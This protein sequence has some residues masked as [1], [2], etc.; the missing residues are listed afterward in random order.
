MSE[1]VY[2]FVGGFQNV[3]QSFM[4]AHFELFPGIFIGMRTGSDRE[5]MNIGWKRNRT[6]DFGAG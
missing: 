5:F 2:G 1:R 4:N 3:Y 6:G